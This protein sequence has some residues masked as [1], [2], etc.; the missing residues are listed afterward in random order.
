MEIH[1]L[2]KTSVYTVVQIEWIEW[3]L[4]CQKNRNHILITACFRCTEDN[5]ISV[6]RRSA[7]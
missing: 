3:R 6:Q 4:V 2:I 5:Y 7:C 1:S